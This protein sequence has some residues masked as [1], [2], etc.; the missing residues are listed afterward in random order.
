MKQSDQI[1]EQNDNLVGYPG[2][3]AAL[4]LYEVHSA[5]QGETSHI[6]EDS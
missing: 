3:A 4:Y 2:L 1:K 6:E 5:Q